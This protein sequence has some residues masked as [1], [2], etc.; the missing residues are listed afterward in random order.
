MMSSTRSPTDRPII[1]PPAS[2]DQAPARIARS[3]AAWLEFASADPSQYGPIARL[4]VIAT[5]QG[6]EG[7]GAAPRVPGVRELHRHTGDGS[8]MHPF[9]RSLLPSLLHDELGTRSFTL[10]ACLSRISSAHRSVEYWM[11]STSRRAPN[12]GRATGQRTR[13]TA[14]RMCR[15]RRGRALERWAAQR[16]TQRATR[17]SW[18]AGRPR[19]ARREGCTLDGD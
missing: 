10:E 16:A 12:R 13:E 6:G 5:W 3:R 14:R 17:Q 8:C 1:C 18:R 19:G 7:G 2:G 11:L 9:V 15:Q 4:R